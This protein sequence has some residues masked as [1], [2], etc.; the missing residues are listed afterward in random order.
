MR[1]AEEVQAY[2]Y[3]EWGLT[4]SVAM[5]G[6]NR[7]LLLFYPNFGKHSVVVQVWETMGFEVYANDASNKTADTLAWLKKLRAA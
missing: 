6:P 4:A 1:T 5:K 3:K 7:S 2:F